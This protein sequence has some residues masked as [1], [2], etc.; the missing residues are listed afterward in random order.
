MSHEEAKELP[1]LDLRTDLWSV[2]AIPFECLTG[3]APHL[4]DAYEQIIISICTT[5]APD[6]RS[7]DPSIPAELAAVVHRAL[8][9]DPARRFPTAKEMLQALQTT[10]TGLPPAT[11]VT[12]PPF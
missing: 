5:D 7:I 9:R 12:P 11:A 4:G 10:S 3:R 2:G 8:T 6:V 1:D